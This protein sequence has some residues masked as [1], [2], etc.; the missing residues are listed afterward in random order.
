MFVAV[1]SDVTLTWRDIRKHER[2]P[3][4]QRLRKLSEAG[5]NGE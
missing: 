5:H 2:L 3:G 4:H 1:L